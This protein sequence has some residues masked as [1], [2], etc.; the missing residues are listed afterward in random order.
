M[1]RQRLRATLAAKRGEGEELLEERDVGARS[2]HTE[3]NTKGGDIKPNQTQ[4]PL[5]NF[6]VMVFSFPIASAL[7]FFPQRLLVSRTNSNTRKSL[8]SKGKGACVVGGV[9]GVCNFTET[10]GPVGPPPSRTNICR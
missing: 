2:H 4:A 9:T 5:S 8:P 1:A 6:V 10:E 3:S 7:W